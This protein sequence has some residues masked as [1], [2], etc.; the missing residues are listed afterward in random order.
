MMR[1]IQLCSLAFFA[2]QGLVAQTPDMTIAEQAKA[3]KCASCKDLKQFTSGLIQPYSTSLERAKAIYAWVGQ[4]IAYDYQKSVLP[5]KS[6]VFSGS[7]KE[8][9]AQ[10]QITVT[11]SSKCAKLQALNVR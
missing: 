10:K 5:G 9:I 2:V 8:E 3:Y 4:Y 6:I 11:C 7:T 1:L